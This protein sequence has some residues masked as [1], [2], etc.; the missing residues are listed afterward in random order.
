MFDFGKNKRVAEGVK[1]LQMKITEQS[2]IFAI[3]LSKEIDTNLI[4]FDVP[5]YKKLITSDNQDLEAPTCLNQISFANEA[6]A[7]FLHVLAR[8]CYS[9]SMDRVDTVIMKPTI[10]SQLELSARAAK[11]VVDQ[12]I[13]SL[14]QY[15]TDLYW[16]RDQQYG[17][18]KSAIGEKGDDKSSALY[19]AGQV[20]STEAQ[21]DL[22]D[23]LALYFGGL[24]TTF[25]QTTVQTLLLKGVFQIKIPDR[26]GSLIRDLR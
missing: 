8:Q 1:A 3:D 5:R 7:F 11:S 10:L 13:E 25:L 4:D 20:I 16:R 24:S 19:V 14:R 23:H 15:V 9:A 2:Y 21:P 12:D 26:L 17:K 18:C 6:M 22:L